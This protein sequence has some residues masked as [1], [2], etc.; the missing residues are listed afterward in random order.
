MT[1]GI[2]K[3][4]LAVQWLCMLALA[5]SY[6]DQ[7]S[8]QDF[9]IRRPTTVILIKRLRKASRG[10][11]T[12]EGLPQEKLDACWLW[13]LLGLS[14]LVSL[15]PHQGRHAVGV[16]VTAK[17]KWSGYGFRA[18]CLLLRES[19]ASVDESDH[20]Q[21]KQTRTDT[22]ASCGDL[23][24]ES[25]YRR[26]SAIAAGVRCMHCTYIANLLFTKQ[27]H[28]NL[29]IVDAGRDALFRDHAEGKRSKYPHVLRRSS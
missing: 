16:M 24:C 10:S 14:L 12:R 3:S 11:K 6:Q 4:G 28:K 23:L 29:R 19:C 1:S 22:C 26:S 13:V 15:S 7:E 9:S 21:R 5:S 20:A 2:V 25:A 18:A 8:D 17:V 27:Q